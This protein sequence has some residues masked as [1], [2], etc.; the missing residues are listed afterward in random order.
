MHGD[1]IFFVSNHYKNRNNRKCE[2]YSENIKKD[3]NN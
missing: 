1:I 2:S 3:K